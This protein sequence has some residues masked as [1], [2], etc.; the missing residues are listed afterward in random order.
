MIKPWMWSLVLLVPTVELRA[1][2]LPSFAG[3]TRSQIQA[4]QMQPPGPPCAIKQL[5]SSFK[6]ICEIKVATRFEGTAPPN[7]AAEYLP[8]LQMTGDQYCRGWLVASY[9]WEASALYHHPLY[10]EEVALE[11]YGHTV[12]LIQPAVSAAH[13]FISVPLLPYKMMLEPPHEHVYSLGYY[14]PGSA[15]PR[16]RYPIPLRL[17]GAT[18]EAAIIMGLIL[19]LP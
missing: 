9:Q 6:P 2:P 15:A 11:R 17:D 12:P 10:F 18:L 7:I 19:V 4:G 8:P 16:L 1:D 14:R 13:F 5:P 3:A